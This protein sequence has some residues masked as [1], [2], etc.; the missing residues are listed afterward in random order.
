VGEDGGFGSFGPWVFDG[1]Y[2]SAVQ[3]RMDNGL[4][5][6]TAAP[7]NQS[8]RIARKAASKIIQGDWP[9]HPNRP[10]G[11]TRSS[12]HNYQGQR[13]DNML[14]GDGHLEYSKLPATMDVTQVVDVNFTW[15]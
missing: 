5:T 7:A 13:R 3:Q 11:D 6:G 1:T 9:W 4:K 12:W 10:V 15:W 14:Y 2:N 8:S